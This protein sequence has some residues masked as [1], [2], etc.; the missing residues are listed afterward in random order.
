[1]DLT[2]AND[3]PTLS[4]LNI[5]KLTDT[6]ATDTFSD[7]TGQLAGKDADTGDT[8]TYSVLNADHH[9]TTTVAGHYG[10]LTVNSDGSY[11][12]V[13]NAAA[14]NALSS[15]DHTDTFTVQTTDAHD[16]T[17]T[18]TLSVDVTGANDAPAI[19]VGAMA[20]THV[21]SGITVSGLSVTDVDA[22][23][24]EVTATAVADSGSNA[25]ASLQSGALT[26]NYTEPRDGP[27]TDKVAVTVTDGHGA[28]DTVNL[29]FNL[30]EEGTVNLA[31]TTSKDVLFG[32]N[33]QDQFRFAANSNHDTIVNF[34]SGQDHI[35]LSFLNASNTSDWMAHHVTASGADTLITIDA[36]DTIL[37]KGVNAA[38]LHASDFILHV[39]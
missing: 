32:T 37:L 36:A 18:A 13:P 8:L 22:A 17:A 25:S 11:G 1:M 19:N 27:A 24:D 2:G 20:V 28:S 35:D 5:G 7:I 26:I 12:Y 39:T 15:G 31:S 3:T 33:Y 38:N 9:A 21:E 29:I 6:A 34:T 14:I 10:S 23:S 30:T 4:D 16:A